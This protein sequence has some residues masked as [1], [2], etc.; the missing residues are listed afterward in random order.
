MTEL[1]IYAHYMTD[2]YK[3]LLTGLA[4]K[5]MLP[6]LA[7]IVMVGHSKFKSEYMYYE[8]AIKLYVI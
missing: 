1:I 7:F 3:N 5:N 4:N 6:I 2:G 8:S